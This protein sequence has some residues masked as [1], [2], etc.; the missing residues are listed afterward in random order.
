MKKIIP[1]LIALLF[2]LAVISCDTSKTNSSDDQKFE[3]HDLDISAL[4][5]NKKGNLGFSIRNKSQN[6]IVV[7]YYHDSLN[8]Y[9][10][11]N[12]RH[13]V[14]K[15]T[16]AIRVVPIPPAEEKVIEKSKAFDFYV[17]GSYAG[18]D[19]ALVVFPYKVISEKRDTLKKT[20]FLCVQLNGGSASSFKPTAEIKSILNFMDPNPTAPTK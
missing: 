19:S 5:L 15:G 4:H 13:K 18:C 6:N 10:I 1:V 7:N 20:F 14:I 11:C 2:A 3:N 17:H 8:S 16:W 12:E 9:I